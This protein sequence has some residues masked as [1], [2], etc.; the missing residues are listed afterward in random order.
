ME[1]KETQLAMHMQD[2]GQGTARK[3]ELDPNHH[4]QQQA[5]TL[6]QLV[7]QDGTYTAPN[8]NRLGVFR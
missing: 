3:A 7:L 1:R 2:Q 4:Q 6:G 8:E 5:G